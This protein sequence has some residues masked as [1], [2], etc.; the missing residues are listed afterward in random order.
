MSKASKG[1]LRGA[2]PANQAEQMRGRLAGQKRVAL[3]LINVLPGHNAR[4][5]VFGDQS[6]AGKGFDALVES[7]RDSGDVLQS[8]LVR[9]V[10]DNTYDLIAGERRLRACRAAGLESVSVIERPMD[11]VEAFNASVAE[12]QLREEVAEVELAQA[13]L[14]NLAK[15]AGVDMAELRSALIWL[16]NHNG[17]EPEKDSAASRVQAKLEVMELPSLDKLVNS[18][19]RLLYLTDEENAALR[20]GYPTKAV[21]E[22]VRLAEHPER[23]ALLERAVEGQ[24]SSKQVK[25]EVDRLLGLA[26]AQIAEPLQQTLGVTRRAFSA[27]RVA[28]LS[29]EDQ[30]E[31]DQALKELVARYGLG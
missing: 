12:N 22:L 26:P 19:S 3:H 31:L 27:K 2:V 25:A 14:H 4:G 1:Q 24:W 10:G 8:L 15:L 18:W 5:A 13:S 30:L 29:A 20:D 16:R 23:S 17:E 7:I 9:P 28:R 11:S 21:L 6:F